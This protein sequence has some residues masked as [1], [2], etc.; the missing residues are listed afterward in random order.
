M[1]EGTEIRCWAYVTHPFAEV[2]EAIE[3]EPGRFFGE[4]TKRAVARAESLRTTLKVNVAGFE[5][6]RDV[7]IEVAALDLMRHPPHEPNAPAVTLELRWKAAS[8]LGVTPSSVLIL[9]M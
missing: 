7:I 3:S 2:R 6:G 9:R 1:S 4:P 5:I 8:R